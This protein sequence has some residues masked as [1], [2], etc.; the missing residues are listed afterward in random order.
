[1]NKPSLPP[2]INHYHDPFTLEQ[3]L[4]VAKIHPFYS[5]KHTS[6]PDYATVAQAARNLSGLSASLQEMPITKKERLA[7]VTNRLSSNSAEAKSFRSGAIIGITG[8]GSGKGVPMPFFTDAQETVA[9]R[10]FVGKLLVKC[11]AVGVG[12]VAI[13]LNTTGNLYRSVFNRL[14]RTC[15]QLQPNVLAVFGET[16]RPISFGSIYGSAE[17][18]PWAVAN[19]NLSGHHGDYVDLIYDKKAMV[20]EIIPVPS[21]NVDESA[22]R[23][24]V[25]NVPHGSVGV[26][27]LTSLQKLRHPLVRY[28]TGDLGSLHD[29][30]IEM[31][32]YIGEGTC[33]LGVL[34]MYGRDRT[35][36]FKWQANFY[37]LSAIGNAMKTA[38]WGVLDWQ[39]SLDIN[40]DSG[41][42]IMEVKLIR[43]EPS[44]SILSDSELSKELSGYFN[45][46]PKV[47]HLFKIRSVGLQ[48]MVRSETAGKIIRLVDKTKSS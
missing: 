15:Q 20:V 26:I 24:D 1:M 2:Q 3:V 41:E 32:S 40:N 30:T 5:D 44:V 48:D 47:D 22:T 29:L 11:G 4:A 42:H 38:H 17:A 12:D 46:Y 16:T 13:V 31:H 10:S 7:E 34:R 21:G 28:Y 27:A 36:S 33:D 37:E 18:G 19:H 9:I 35:E 25:E 43:P 39:I 14:V 8:G 23:G 6:A 45:V